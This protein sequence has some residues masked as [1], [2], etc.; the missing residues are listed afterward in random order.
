MTMTMTFE[1]YDDDDAYIEKVDA[2]IILDENDLID[3]FAFYNN[4]WKKAI[5]AIIANVPRAIGQGMVGF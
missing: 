3:A 4:D 2:K 1:L 5:A